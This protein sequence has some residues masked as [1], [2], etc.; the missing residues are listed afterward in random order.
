MAQT[1]A[2]P[3]EFEV[4]SVKPYSP[5]VVQAGTRK[6]A[7]GRRGGPG[8]NDPGQ[9][10]WTGATLRSLVMNA[11]SVKTYQIT[12]PEWLDSERF[13]IVAKVPEGA[14]KEQVLVMWQSLLAARFGLKFHRENKEI[15]VYEISIGK[16]GPKF[17]EAPADPPPVPQPPKPATDGPPVVRVTR[18]PDGCPVFPG[19]RGGT[20]MMMTLGRF[21]ICAQQTTMEGLCNLLTSQ[22]SRPIFDKTG[23]TGKYNFKL[24]FEPE[25]AMAMPAMGSGGIASATQSGPPSERPASAPNMEPAPPIA[26]AL[27]NQLG[28]KLESR[29]AP[30]EMLIIDKLEKTPTEN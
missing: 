18:G 26:A 28:L 6:S 7:V 14:T 10:T 13:D 17:K 25:G 8:T 24:E 9:I 22:L 4:A 11:W 30:A 2:A 23:L 12:G 21:Q 1:A 20:T 15:P 16:G 5:P 19:G 27:Q 3:T 29:K